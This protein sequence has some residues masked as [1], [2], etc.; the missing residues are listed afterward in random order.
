MPAFIC[1]LFSSRVASSSPDSPVLEAEVMSEWQNK[2]LTLNP[3]E[4]L[5]KFW[6]NM[7]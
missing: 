1:S 2:F 6:F 4:Q 5:V 3:T 7:Y